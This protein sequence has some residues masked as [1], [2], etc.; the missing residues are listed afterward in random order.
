MD[1]LV[2]AS[3]DGSGC[4][5]YARTARVQTAIPTT[6]G[7]LLL[8]L[9][10][11][12]TRQPSATPEL[13]L[14]VCLVDRPP[15]DTPTIAGIDETA[16]VLALPSPRA[17]PRA[18]DSA[19]RAFDDFT[20]KHV[21]RLGPSLLLRPAPIALYDYATCADGVPPPDEYTGDLVAARKAILPLA[22]LYMC[23][24]T[25][26]GV[27]VDKGFISKRLSVLVGLWPDGNP[28]R[29]ALKRVNECL[30]GNVPVKDTVVEGE[31]ISGG[32]MS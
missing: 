6:N 2:D 5:D 7:R 26:E 11:P 10:E 31:Q 18:Y 24:L 19:L 28:P 1:R 9:G 20:S 16:A 32:E 3:R 21:G 22:L 23:I 8:E 27:K 30:I 4:T 12:A 14:H 29:A 13:T 15:S 17:Y 25:Q